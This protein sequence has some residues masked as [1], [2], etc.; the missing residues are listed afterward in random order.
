MAGQQA[1][2]AQRV[3]RA[4]VTER[5]AEILAAI[6]ERLRNREI[7]DRLFISVRTVESH[8]SALLRK[9]DVP[10]RA[11]LAKL[12]LE[13]RRTTPAGAVLPAPLTSLVGR[14]TELGE[15]AALVDAHRLVTLVGPAGVGKT[16]LALRLATV[17]TE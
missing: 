15:L 3:A 16:R 4:G 5:E 14:D 10:D 1:G 17:H 8:I 9:L 11:A 2:V 13:L 12:G 7:A 6:A